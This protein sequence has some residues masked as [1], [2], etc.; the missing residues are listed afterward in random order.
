VSG[1][2][3]DNFNVAAKLDLRRHFLRR[4]HEPPHGEARVMDACAGSGVLWG[5]LRT[6]FALASYW[7]M[8][9][10]PKKGRLKIDSVR[11]LSQ[12]GWTQ[13]VVDCDTYGSPWSHWLALLPTCQPPLTVFLTVGCPNI[14][15]MQKNSIVEEI[16]G[17]SKLKR[18]VPG[19]ISG[20][21]NHTIGAEFL[22]AQAFNHGLQIVEAVEAISDGTARYFG[23]RLE[24]A[25]ENPQKT[26]ES[27]C[28]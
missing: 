19:T 27:Q 20:R 24:K 13:N 2:K 23:V 25:A 15:M 1:K 8:D 28:F 16:L 9:L 5:Q 14:G 6:E 4:Y 21:L 3:T 18:E 10:K 7:Q 11:V 12:K 22:L 26:D 17:L